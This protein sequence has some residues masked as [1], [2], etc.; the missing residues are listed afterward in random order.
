M[1]PWT[2][3]LLALCVLT[4]APT[5]FAQAVP[6]GTLDPNT[7][8]K[9]V[10]PLVIPPVLLDDQGGTSPIDAEVT[11]K[12]INQQVLPT[13]FPMTP[14]WAYGTD[15]KGFNNPAFTIEVTKDIGSRIKWINGLVDDDGN[16]LPHIIQDSA[17]NPVE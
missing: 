10:T 6:G 14:L 9:Y 2:R 5:A 12:Q 16:Y 15:A 8:P 3:G 1:K 13:G 17:G 4:A 11:I 7:I